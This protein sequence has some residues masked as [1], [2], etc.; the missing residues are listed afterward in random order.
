MC[1]GV[2][3]TVARVEALSPRPRNA[4]RSK[5]WSMKLADVEGQQLEGSD[6]LIPQPGEAPSASTSVSMLA[7]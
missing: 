4:G 2:G 3:S 5:R 6:A 7:P 1:D